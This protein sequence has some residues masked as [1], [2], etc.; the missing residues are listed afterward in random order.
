MAS[1]LEFEEH[2]KILQD[3]IKEVEDGA[4]NLRNG[5]AR[6]LEELQHAGQNIAKAAAVC[7]EW[8][9]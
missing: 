4:A 7:Q 8:T 2:M 6:A 9:G 1:L 3:G 5:H